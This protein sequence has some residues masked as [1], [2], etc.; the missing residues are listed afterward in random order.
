MAEQINTTE[1]SVIDPENATRLT[2]SYNRFTVD[3]FI[4]SSVFANLE[5]VYKIFPEEAAE[6]A[7]VMKASGDFEDEENA[8]AP[9][10]VLICGLFRD[11]CREDRTSEMFDSIIPIL[12]S[13]HALLN[14]ESFEEEVNNKSISINFREVMHQFGFDADELAGVMGVEI[15]PT[16]KPIRL[17]SME[18]LPDFIPEEVKQ[19]MRKLRDEAIANGITDGTHVI[20][21]T[22][23]GSK[24]I[25]KDEYD[26]MHGE[27]AF[28]ASLANF[29]MD[30]EG[31]ER[32]AHE[33]PKTLQ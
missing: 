22:P 32:G 23:E 28:D 4:D 21:V 8:P 18:D 12:V 19:Q 13:A 7:E 15:L 29:K 20:Q 5:N 11:F 6:V 1:K 16:G 24:V 26:E 14:T 25:C 10:Q 31:M 27:G 2:V 30:I 3:G 33:A 9:E 17:N